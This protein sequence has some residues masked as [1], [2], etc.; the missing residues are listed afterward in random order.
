MFDT[1][2]VLP[3]FALDAP[4]VLPMEDEGPSFA[5]PANEP[6]VA[7]PRPAC[8]SST[9]PN[10]VARTEP[11]RRAAAPKPRAARSRKTRWQPSWPW[12]RS[13]YR[14]ATTKVPARWSKE[15]IAEATGDLKAKA[16]RFAEQSWADQGQRA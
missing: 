12:R 11:A 10:P 9:W 8:S 16:E 13:S 3:D 15:V 1:S 7:S 14:S 6:Y 4:P 5:M 2:E